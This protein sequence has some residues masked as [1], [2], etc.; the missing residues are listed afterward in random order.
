MFL[1]RELQKYQHVVHDTCVS[2]ETSVSTVENANL[3]QALR[4]A[5]VSG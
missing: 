4:E 2:L 3:Q 1:E 5:K